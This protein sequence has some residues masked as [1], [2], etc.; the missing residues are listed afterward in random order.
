MSFLP[1]DLQVTK[2]SD[3][4]QG[5]GQKLRRGQVE[6]RHSEAIGSAPGFEINSRSCLDNADTSYLLLKD[7]VTQFQFVSFQYKCDR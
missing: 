7:I 4:A 2:G 5:E 1:Q 3:P 6:V